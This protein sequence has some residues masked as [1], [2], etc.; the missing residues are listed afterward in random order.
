MVLLHKPHSALLQF[1]SKI[2]LV[3][4]RLGTDQPKPVNPFPPQPE[5]CLYFY[6]YDTISSYNYA[7]QL[8]QQAP[9][10]MLAG[11]KLSRVDLTMGYDMLVIQVVFQPGGM[12]RLLNI[13]MKEMIDRPFDATLF[14]GSEVDGIS[15]RLGETADYN[16]M[17]DIVQMWLLKKVKV[18]KRIL[19]VEQVLMQ[20]M[21]QRHFGNIDRLAKQACISTRQLE[22]QFLERIGMPP[23]LFSRLARFSRAWNI[24]ELNPDITW[25]SI[26]HTCGYADQMHMIRDFKTFAG[27]TPGMLQRD[28]EKSPLRLQRDSN[29]FIS[30]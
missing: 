19:P 15:Q 12:Y 28:L 6:P 21:Q 8:I 24:R 9:R 3:H 2:V 27:V 14:L 16:I 25:L 30:L 11:P 7:T 26:A 10:S 23:K 4:Y 20:T 22:R 18:L 5:H 29:L 1:I 17:I 13:P